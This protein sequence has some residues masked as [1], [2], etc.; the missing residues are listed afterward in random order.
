MAITKPTPLFPTYTEL[1]ELSLSDYPQLSSFLDKQPIWMRQHWDW[2]KE[3]LL[4]IGRNKSQ[5]TYV[6]FRNDIEKFLLWVFMVD[7]QPVDDLR[8]AD[9]LR[10]IDFCVAPPVKWIST[11]LHDRFSLNNG[12]FASNL[13]WTPFRQTP[14]KY[15]KERVLDPKKYQPSLQTLESTFVALSS[16]YRHLI[17]EEICFGNPIP[18]AKRDCKYM[19]KDSQVKT[20]SRLTEQQW[21]YLLDTAVEM[22]DNDPLVERNLFVIATMKTL[23][24]RLSELSERQDWTPLMSHFWTD[25]DNNWWFKAYGKGKKIRDITVPP[26]YLT[27]LKRYREWRGLSPLPSKGEQTVLVEKIRGR[28][29]LTSRQISRLVQHVFDEA[30]DKMKSEHGVEAAQKLNEATTHYLRHTGASMEIERDRPL[31]DLSE[32][33]GH[34]SSATTDTVYVQVERKRRASSGKDRK[35]E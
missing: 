16:F 5:H 4:Y 21:Q 13:K 35:V 1:A 24:L 8:K 3:Y 28:G 27:F 18:L 23:F 22:A 26:G 7:K 10:Y 2:A 29:G 6:R 14:P 12:Y 32:D 17:D 25:E 34:S 9:I 33:L 20:I 19:I 11:Q 31:K 15:D 30:F